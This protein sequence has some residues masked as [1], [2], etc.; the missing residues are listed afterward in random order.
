MRTRPAIVA[1]LAALV[2]LGAACGAGG[3]DT[4][5]A[6]AQEAADPTDRADDVSAEDR[7]AVTASAEAAAPPPHS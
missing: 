2:L 7:S 6:G 4:P 5:V 3:E 1:I